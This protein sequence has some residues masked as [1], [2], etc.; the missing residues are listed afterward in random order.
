MSLALYRKYRPQTF[1]ELVGQQPIRI[2]LEQQVKSGRVGHAYLFVGP[3]GVGKTTTARILAKA[4][5]CENR[6]A[7]DAEPCNTCVSC[8]SITKGSSLNILEIDAAS[9]TGVDNVREVIINGVH[10]VTQKDKWKIFII[11]EVHM[12]S[13]AAFN[14]LLKTLEEPPRYVVFILATT[15]SHK[16]PATIISRCQR[17][18][19]KL[20]AQDALTKRVRLLADYEGMKLTDGV[21]ERVVREAR[22]SVRDAESVLQQLASLEEKNIADELADLL[23]PASDMEAV[24][25]WFESLAKKNVAAAIDHLE[26]VHGAGIDAG[27]FL[28]DA[29]YL[30]HHLLLAQT[31]AK[32]IAVADVDAKI[33]PRVQELQQRL[34]VERL[35]R[36][37]ALLYEAQDLV[38]TSTI[39]QL[40][41]EVATVK[42]CGDLS[43]SH[44]EDTGNDP[45][46]IPKRA[47]TPQPQK[48]EVLQKNEAVEIEKAESDAVQAEPIQPKKE[49]DI[50][51]PLARLQEK[52]HTLVTQTKKYNHALQFL[53]EGSTPF[54]CENGC[55]TFGVGYKMHADKL[56]D[57]KMRNALVR[58]VEDVYGVT[59][60]ILP[61]VGKGA[62]GL[63]NGMAHPMQPSDDL[64]LQ[65]LVK[66]FGG[67]IIE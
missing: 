52:W 16:V 55:L 40:P 17:F 35:L 36:L 45:G 56:R 21:V 10:V 64:H 2:T 43:Q 20:V 32:K 11:D 25:V 22:G 5:N 12:L 19:F 9:H 46:T 30:A 15:E 44:D 67:Q 7:G 26:A 59:V 49:G 34:H 57:T 63:G 18:D 14:A 61:E 48:T 24:V 58:A 29:L 31:S 39:P 62:N 47:A 51:L 23:F 27:A 6:K 54:A 28:G 65:E 42:F 60:R 1:G 3:R 13:T 38:R 66:K 37:V 8:T 33:F 4:L 50:S 41:A 53:L